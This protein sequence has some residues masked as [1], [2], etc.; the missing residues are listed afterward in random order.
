MCSS[1]RAAS[2]REEVVDYEALDGPDGLPDDTPSRHVIASSN[3]TT[4]LPL[5]TATVNT[6]PP[7]PSKAKLSKV[8]KT[9]L[10][11]D[12]AASQKRTALKDAQLHAVDASLNSPSSNTVTPDVRATPIAFSDQRNAPVHDAVG[13]SAVRAEAAQHNGAYCH[14]I[15]YLSTFTDFLKVIP[16]LSRQQFLLYPHMHSTT[17]IFQTGLKFRCTV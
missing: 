13:S 17:R 15:H 16:L 3:V 6:A 8:R 11:N 7:K 12:V 9:S 1:K 4:I 2:E 5:A 14:S 10:A